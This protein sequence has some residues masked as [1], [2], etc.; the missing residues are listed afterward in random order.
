[1]Q[2]G[3]IFLRHGAWFLRYRE[4]SPTGAWREVCKRLATYEHP[5]RSKRAVEKLAQ[6]Y[7]NGANAPRGKGDSAQ[8]LETFV[9]NYY[10]PYVEEALA[11]MTARSY[12]HDWD[13]HVAG[14]ALARKALREVRA[15]MV[16]GFFD[17]LEHKN[18]ARSSHRRI[19]ALLSSILTYARVRCDMPDVLP[20]LAGV[21]VGGDKRQRPAHAYTLDEIRRILAALPEPAKTLVAL[22][23]FSGLRRS[24]LEGL[25]WSDLDEEGL[26]VRRTRSE[27][28]LRDGTKTEASASNVPVLPF[29]A[30]TL[31]RHSR[32]NPDTTWMFEGEKLHRPLRIENLKNRTILPALQAAKLPWR[33]WHAF[34]RGLASNLLEIGVEPQ[35]IQQILRHSDVRV[36]LQHYAKARER[37]AVAALRK[38]ERV[39]AKGRKSVE[40]RVE[41][42]V[43]RNRVKSSS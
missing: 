26:H 11:P 9:E 41:Q 1:M 39:F 18:L 22:A 30:K 6:K 14:S 25:Q 24:E 3:H 21:K 42:R 36:T 28:V 40:Q 15:A 8:A 34:R 37:N 10:L 7:L 17:D 16:Q 20:S 38:L 2:R 12:R 19:K 27:G 31:E 4:P 23:A 35:T 33:G 13:N 43:P 32:R 29:L 5:Y